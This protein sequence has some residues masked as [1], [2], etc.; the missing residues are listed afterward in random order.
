[1]N[2]EPFD[3]TFD[4]GRAELFE[5]LGHPL[6]IEILRALSEAPLGFADLKRKV[7]IASSGHLSHHLEKLDGLIGTTPA[8]TYSLTDDGKEA[9]RIVEASGGTL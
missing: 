6:R 1:M 7:G 8:G 5:A 9:L 2:E 4:K 3:D